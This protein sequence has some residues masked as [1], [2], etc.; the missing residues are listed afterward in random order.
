MKKIF[1]SLLALGCLVDV[2]QRKLHSNNIPSCMTK[3]VL[4]W[5]P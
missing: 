4:S 3:W 2:R 1:I 5:K